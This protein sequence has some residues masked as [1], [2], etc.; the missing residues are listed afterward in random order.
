MFEMRILSYLTIAF[1]LYFVT[2]TGQYAFVEDKTERFIPGKVDKNYDTSPKLPWDKV[3]FSIFGPQEIESEKVEEDSTIVDDMAKESMGALLGAIPVVGSV[4]QL[5]L[6]LLFKLADE[7]EWKN[8]FKENILTEVDQKSAKDEIS[9]LVA[10]IEAIHQSLS[11][12][13]DVSPETI[14]WDTRKDLDYMMNIFDAHKSIFK[15]YPLLGAPILIELANFISKF[16]R[17]INDQEI[18]CKM[19]NILYEY[20][21]R[22]VIARLDKISLEY[23][24]LP[25][26]GSVDNSKYDLPL[27]RSHTIDLPFENFYNRAEDWSCDFEYAVHKDT[28]DIYKLMQSHFKE[29]LRVGPVSL[30]VEPDHFKQYMLQDEFG[31]TYSF[32]LQLTDHQDPSF[33]CISEYFGEVRHRVEKQFPIE[34]FDKFCTEKSQKPSGN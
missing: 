33:Y 17:I 5:F 13:G 22:T 12:A 24:P 9:K 3:K 28:L 29:M 4:A 2:V 19:R 6:S 10:L 26:R 34:D 11:N 31:R 8:K 23:F 27:I 16:D 7:S 15:R 32:P 1:A 20:S 30:K 14:A 18:S 25:Q 21:K